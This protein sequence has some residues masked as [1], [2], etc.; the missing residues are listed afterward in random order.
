MV[1]VVPGT[2]FS[3]ENYYVVGSILQNMGGRMLAPPLTRYTLEV[4]NRRVYALLLFASCALG[5]CTIRCECL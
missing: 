2:V 1:I 5:M 4:G 3:A